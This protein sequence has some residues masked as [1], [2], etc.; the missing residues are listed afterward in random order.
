MNTKYAKCQH[1]NLADRKAGPRMPARW[2]SFATEICKCGAWK[3]VGGTGWNYTDIKTD[4]I[5]AEKEQENL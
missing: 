1:K 2:G 3:L 5:A 4:L